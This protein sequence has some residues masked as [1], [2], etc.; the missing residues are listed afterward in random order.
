MPTTLPTA[1]VLHGGGGLPTVAPLIAHLSETHD[2][3]APTHPGWDGTPRDPSVATIGDLAARYLA[4]LEERDARDVLVVGSSLGGWIAA[5]LATRAPARLGALVLIDAVGIAVPEE[6]IADFFALDARGL[7]EHAFHDADRFYADPT[8]LPPQQRERM[9]A[10]AQTMRALAGDPYMNDPSL[11][12][13]LAAIPTPALVLWGAADR[14]VTPAY[15]R[16]YAA[17][18]GA[19]ARFALLP[20][21][22][23]LPQLET[24]TAVFAAL[25][26]FAGAERVD[27]PAA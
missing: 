20:D 1:L 27:R 6:P 11:R 8:T 13:R 23:H 9:A 10:N 17:A 21:T 19:N 24:P 22:G 3:L 25:D 7:A 16:A 18:I 15:G 14:I 4:L 26:A 5:E 12:A 2:V